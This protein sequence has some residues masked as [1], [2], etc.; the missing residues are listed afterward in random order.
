VRLASSSLEID[1]IRLDGGTQ[2]REGLDEAWVSELADLYREGHEIDPVLVVVETRGEEVIHWLADGFHR[3]AAKRRTGSNSIMA[4]VRAGSA[5]TLDMAKMLA[6]AANKNG[7]PLKPGEKRRA[8]LLARST[9]E[10]AAMGVVDLAKHCGVTKGYVSQILG[11]ARSS[12]VNQQPV[13]QQPPP[14]PRPHVARLHARVDEA[15]RADPSKPASLVAK[16]L[17]CDRSVVARRRAALGL[18]ALSATER[19]NSSSTK[20]VEAVLRADPDRKSVDIARETGANP[21]TITRARERLGLPPPDGR[22]VAPS[23]PTRKGGDVRDAAEVIQARPSA[24]AP[25][26]RRGFTTT[27]ARDVAEVALGLGDADWD[28]MVSRRAARASAA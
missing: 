13:L 18:P 21:R 4:T 10:G 12:V 6:A 3:V 9:P 20:A 26:P 1:R 15:L 27:T 28:L 7:R 2:V 14:D 25:D 23:A 24:P 17:D 19:R 11:E 8:V 22:S 16:D 5:A